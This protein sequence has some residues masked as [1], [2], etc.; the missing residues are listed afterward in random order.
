MTLPHQLPDVDHAGACH[1]GEPGV[2]DMGVVLPHDCF[3]TGVHGASS[4]RSSV[5][6]HVMVANVPE[7][8]SAT[9]HRPV[10]QLGALRDDRILLGGEVV[11]TR[12][13]PL[14]SLSRDRRA[15]RAAT[16]SC[17]HEVGTKAVARAYSW[18]S[19]LYGSKQ[20]YA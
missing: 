15:T 8:R 16:A 4:D 7:V 10:I 12:P 9:N 1:V 5:S 11:V 19:S 20:E 14:Y 6:D 2:A 17:W 3:R 18:A 13:S